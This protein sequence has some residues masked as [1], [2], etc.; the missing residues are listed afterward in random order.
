MDSKRDASAP[1]DLQTFL[2]RHGSRLPCTLKVVEGFC[3]TNAEDTLEGDQILVIYKV[4]KQNTIIALDHLNQ[5]ICVP[6]NTK[7]KVQLLPFKHHKEHKRVRDLFNAHQT[8]YFRVLEDLVSFQIPSETTLQLLSNQPSPNF[9]KCKVVDLY[10]SREVFLPLELE[11]R[12]QPL[13]DAREYYLEEVL[14]QYQLPVNVRFIPVA[15]RANDGARLSNALSSL[16]NI[17]LEHETEVKM[18][19]AASIDHP[20]SLNLFPRTLDINVS[21]GFKVTA[22]TGKKIKECR[23]TLAASKR[24]LKRLD[25]IASNSFYFKVCPVRRFNFESLQP[26]SISFSQR[27]KEC[28]AELL[29]KAK[30]NKT[31]EQTAPGKDT[32]T[33]PRH[34]QCLQSA[35]KPGW[36]TEG[37]AADYENFETDESFNN[38]VAPE[39]RKAVEQG[40][41]AVPAVPVLPPKLLSETSGSTTPKDTTRA[42]E[43]SRPVPKPRKRLNP[44]INRNQENINSAGVSQAQSQDTSLP[45]WTVPPSGDDAEDICPELPPKPEFLKVRNIEDKEDDESKGEPPP[46][47]PPRCPGP[48]QFGFPAYLV[49]DVT[50][51][52]AVDEKA[53]RP[54]TITDEGLYSDA[55]EDGHVFKQDSFRHVDL[56]LMYPPDERKPY[57]DMERPG[58]NRRS[59]VDMER[60]E[61]MKM[62]GRRSGQENSHRK[63]FLQPDETGT[64]EELD[65]S[66]LR[67][68]G[69]ENGD[70]AT[71]H[72]EEESSD[73]DYPY[74]E[75]EEKHESSQGENQSKGNAATQEKAKVERPSKNPAGSKATQ[76]SFDAR[77]RWAAMPTCPVNQRGII[78]SGHRDED[79]MDF[80]DIARFLEL[81]EQLNEALAKKADLEKQVAVTGQRLTAESQTKQP[82]TSDHSRNAAPH[83]N[84]AESLD[85]NHNRLDSSGEFRNHSQRGTQAATRSESIS[86]NRKTEMQKSSSLSLLEADDFENKEPSPSSPAPKKECSLTSVKELHD[87]DDD[88]DYVECHDREY[89]N[90]Q[91]GVSSSFEDECSENEFHDHYVN[92]EKEQQTGNDMKD[93]DDGLDSIYYNKVE[94]ETNRDGRPLTSL[95]LQLDNPNDEEENVYEDVDTSESDKGLEM[96]KAKGN[97]PA[98]FK[99]IAAEID[100]FIMKKAAC[101]GPPNAVGV[102]EEPPPLPLKLRASSLRDEK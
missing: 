3:G 60:D 99:A 31:A 84:K 48:N 96:I 9:A 53:F 65:N 1:V 93:A 61:K 63:D 5:E 24:T 28:K 97:Q 57:I 22:D 6:R 64:S 52:R 102:I 83:I 8:Q 59:Y 18:V 13:L 88:D 47:L 4:E 95:Y 7:N 45:E 80:K 34:A 89:V 17:H 42:N 16:E 35:S 92:V 90:H 76:G 10:D 71:K 46:P 100:T 85:E 70:E 91:T 69:R 98:T 54:N 87:S 94:L 75:I 56:S 81:R 44:A 78:I 25:I 72:V 27:T 20:L 62:D 2:Q 14:A 37:Q 67:E 12:F 26:P 39:A 68:A 41:E 79:W 40:T 55:K 32:L 77:P 86:F 30:Q 58:V 19:F 82:P 74:E 33:I 73:E 51:W 38:S 50:D 49:V 11:G 66:Q 43:Q 15:S 101:E 21:F 23:Q 36:S 29:S